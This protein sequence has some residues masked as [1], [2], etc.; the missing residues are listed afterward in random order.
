MSQSGGRGF[1]RSRRIKVNLTIW[2]VCLRTSRLSGFDSS[3]VS[4]NNS[5]DNC[6]APPPPNCMGGALVFE[7]FPPYLR[8]PVESQVTLLLIEYVV[9]L[10]LTVI[11]PSCWM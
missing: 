2:S 4:K 10:N 6:R 1:V 11:D 5:R 7:S 8:P 9:G 3:V